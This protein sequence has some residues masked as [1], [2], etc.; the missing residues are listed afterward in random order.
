MG[1]FLANTLTN[2]RNRELDSLEFFLGIRCDLRGQPFRQGHSAHNHRVAVGYTRTACRP[3][4]ATTPGGLQNSCQA[5]TTQPGTSRVGS[6]STRS[7]RID[8]HCHPS[9]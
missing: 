1:K 2:R 9:V 5:G 3:E 6:V 7:Y 4:E 8:E